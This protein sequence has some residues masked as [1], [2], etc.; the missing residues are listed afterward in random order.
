VSNQDI[1]RLADII[2]SVGPFAHP[3]Q[4][5]RAILAAGYERRPER[6]HDPAMTTWDEIR[7]Q[8]RG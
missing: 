8:V 6:D 3:H 2:D 4:I 7:K 1:D 5:A